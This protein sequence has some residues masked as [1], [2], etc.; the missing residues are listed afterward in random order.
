MLGNL[1]RDAGHAEEAAKAYEA[2]L[3]ADPS[4][5]I[6]AVE[7]AAVELLLLKGDPAKG[8]EAVNRALDEKALAALGPAEIARAKS[9]RGVALAGQFKFKEAEAE[10]KDAMEKDPSSLFIKAQLARV[11]RAN[12][13]FAGAL[14][15]YEAAVE[16]GPRQPRVHGGLH[17]LAAHAGQ[18]ADA[19]KAVEA[20]NARFTND[21][22]IALLFGRIDD[23]RDQIA[24]AEGHYQRAIKADPKLFEANLYLGRFYLRLRRNAEARAQLEEAAKKAPERRGRARGPG[25]AG[26]DGEQGG[27]WLSRSSRRPP[28]STPA[29]PRPTWAC[30]AW[31]CS[32]ATWRR[33]R[34]TPTRPWSWIRTCSRTG[35]CSAAPC[36]GGWA[37]WTRPSP[38]WRR[39]SRRIPAR[40]PSPSPWARC[41]TRRATWPA[42]RRT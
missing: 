12:R 21:A 39:P 37:S 5:V 25:R 13:D 3:Q 19:L 8:L 2:A 38:S 42:R 33:P 28:S 27:L 22:R 32:G 35:A 26:P 41:S 14:P 20:A 4:H 7:L 40:S 16:G 1:H 18:D 34:P 36:C 30:P 29:S 10:L 15:L 17:H 6:S 24:A 31:R 9:L 11:L 23:A